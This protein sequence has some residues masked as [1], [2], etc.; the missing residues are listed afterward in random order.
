MPR[1]AFLIRLIRRWAPLWLLPLWLL[2]GPTAHGADTTESQLK[3]ALLY[4]FAQFA[5]WPSLPSDEFRLCVLGESPLVDDLEKLKT[6]SLFRLPVN[7]G[8]PA[9]AAAAK[10][11]QVI[12]LNPASPGELSKWRGALSNLPI[13]T[14]SDAP[15]AWQENM[16][17]VFEVAPGGVKFRINLS[18][19]RAAGL[20][21]SAQMLQLAREVR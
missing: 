20:S 17:I 11:C 2:A 6:K 21:L 15:E 12:Y 1:P 5:T 14:V 3:A 13:L 10:S 7:I 19:A 4:K 8:Y 16:M 18:A 9:S